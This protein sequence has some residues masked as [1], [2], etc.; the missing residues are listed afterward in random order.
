MLKI[1]HGQRNDGGEMEKAWKVEQ[2]AH[3]KTGIQI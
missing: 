3:R 1:S 2:A